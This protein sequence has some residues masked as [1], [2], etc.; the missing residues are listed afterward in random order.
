MTA[1]HQEQR[2]PATGEAVPYL[3]DVLASSVETF[4]VTVAEAGRGT[5]EVPRE[6]LAILMETM[7]LITSGRTVEVVAGKNAELS[8]T[9]AA[10]AL[11]V[12][13]PHLVKLLDRGAIDFRR[14]GTHRRVDATSLEQYQRR[15]QIDTARRRRAA[16]ASAT[17]S[18]E[19]EGLHVSAE[20]AADLD[21]YTH[22]ELD[23]AAVRARALARHTR[24]ADE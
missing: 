12:S 22:G 6:A 11:G 18:T 3:R 24:K 23:A 15:E 17:G 8:T 5:V 13:R 10:R 1:M 9:A 21:A 2:R 20:T 4:H 7:S 19:A 16:V 14:V